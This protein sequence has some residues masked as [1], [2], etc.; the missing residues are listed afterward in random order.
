MPLC[1]RWTSGSLVIA[2]AFCAS[3][4]F[5][6]PPDPVPPPFTPE[7]EVTNLNSATGIVRAKAS[8]DECWSGL[9]QNTKFDFVNQQNPAMPCNTGQIPKVNQGYVWGTAVVG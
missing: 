1:S 4:S 8:P 7:S 6:Q 5:A 9:G 3:L 2:S